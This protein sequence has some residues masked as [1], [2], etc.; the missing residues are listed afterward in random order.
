MDE[1]EIKNL[2]ELIGKRVC[3][4]HNADDDDIGD[5]EFGYIIH[6]W[7]NTDLDAVDCYVAFFGNEWPQIGIQPKDKPYVL[8]YS[9]ASLEECS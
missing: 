6:A 8:R 7:I 5:G 9:L 3:L 2:N 4:K 1:G